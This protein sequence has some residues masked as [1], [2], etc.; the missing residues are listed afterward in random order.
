MQDTDTAV[1]DLIHSRYD[2]TYTVAVDQ[3][4]RLQ[5]PSKWRVSGGPDEELRL[6]SWLT[7]DHRESCILV[8]PP[9]PCADMARKISSMPAADSKAESL[10]RWFGG[11]SARVT[12]D[13][14]GRIT[15]PEHLATK[16]GLKA[17]G[18]AVLVGMNDRFQIWEPGLH[19]ARL[20]EDEAILGDAV[21]LL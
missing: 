12:P 2:Q 14:S 1:L 3:K 7:P 8:L 15:I 11:Q 4:R 18:E 17:D 19:A 21:M 13:K 6:L 9:R 20:K 10:R 16:A 5:V